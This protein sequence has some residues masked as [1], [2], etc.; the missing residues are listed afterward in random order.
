MTIRN[1]AYVFS[2]L[3]MSAAGSAFAIP[4]GDIKMVYF[5]NPDGTFTYVFRVHNMAPPVSPDFRTPADHI[6][7]DR[8]GTPHAAGNKAL[9]DDENLVVFGVDTGLPGV[10]VS[11][12]TNA[13][14]AFHG[15]QETGFAGTVVVAWHL[16]FDGFELSDTILANEKLCFLRFTL[17]QEVTKFQYWIGGSDD[18][19]I[20]ND[21]HTMTEDAFGIYDA[22]DEKYLATFLTREV[23]AKK[24]NGAS[25]KKIKRY[26]RN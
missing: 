23:T 13:K 18:T 24:I 21:A 14:S 8:T 4:L 15:T 7:Y 2:F 5:A 20:W 22:T 12:I 26:L 10:N 19:T 9:S 3:I 6:V 11:K 25:M 1:I 16:P 17:D